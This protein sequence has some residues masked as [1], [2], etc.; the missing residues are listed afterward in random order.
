MMA[1]LRQPGAQPV[2]PA[3]AFERPKLKMH[4]LDAQLDV[5]GVVLI[6]LS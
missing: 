5:E 3:A 1:N 6:I 4:K 2:T